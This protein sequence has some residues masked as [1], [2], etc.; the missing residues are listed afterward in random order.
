MPGT[1]MFFDG[2]ANED[3]RRDLIGFLLI[4]TRK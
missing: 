1:A 4:E 2:I 3:D